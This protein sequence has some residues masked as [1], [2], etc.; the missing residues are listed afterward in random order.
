VGLTMNLGLKLKMEN[1]GGPG[2]PLVLL[3]H[4][5]GIVTFAFAPQFH[6]VLYIHSRVKNIYVTSFVLRKNNYMN[7]SFTRDRC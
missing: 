1:S 4:S 6:F 5:A 7:M 3:I 2:Q